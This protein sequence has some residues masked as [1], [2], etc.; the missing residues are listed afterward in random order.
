MRTPQGDGDWSLGRTQDRYR[1]LV[2]GN[3][4]VS[5]SVWLIDYLLDTGS[6]FFGADICQIA[7]YLDIWFIYTLALLWDAQNL[8]IVA[9]EFLARESFKGK[10]V[11]ECLHTSYSTVILYRHTLNVIVIL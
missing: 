3:E 10:V 11:D 1:Y 9:L 4:Q 5:G 6:S 7:R 8:T 2:T